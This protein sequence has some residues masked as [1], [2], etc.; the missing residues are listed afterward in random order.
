MTLLN[1]TCAS[2]ASAIAVPWWPLLA[3]SGASI[4]NPRMSEIACCSCS[5]VNATGPTVSSGRPVPA[6][7]G[8]GRAGRLWQVDAEHGGERADHPQPR[9][10]QGVAAVEQDRLDLPGG[11][12]AE[13]GEAPPKV[14]RSRSR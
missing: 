12:Q 3:L 4:A 1:S 10:G 6:G 8:D 5:G 11:R 7:S 14:T 2:G 9:A 13:I